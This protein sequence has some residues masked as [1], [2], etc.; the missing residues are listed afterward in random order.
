MSL[1]RIYSLCFLLA[2]SMVFSTAL[3][4]QDTLENYILEYPNQ[5][6]TLMMNKWLEKNEKGTFRF[7][8]LVDPTDDT[9]IT[10]QA[11]VDYGYNWFSVSDAPAIV[12]TPTYD[13]FFSVSVFD[14]K[15]NVPLVVV[16]P[17][18]P[19]VVMRPDQ[20]VPEGDFHVVKLETDQGLIFTRMLVVDN[21][22]EV[23]NLSKSITM[24]GGK[25]DMRRDVQRFSP[26]VEKHALHTIQAVLNSPIGP[27]PDLSFGKVSGDVGML[28]LAAGVFQGQLGTPSDTV[29]YG[30][31][32]ADS[33]GQPL[34]GKDTYLVTVP[35]NIIQHGGYY[36]VTAYGADDKLLIP[37]DKKVYDRTTYSSE[38]NEDGTYTLTLSP[39]GAG[40]NGIPTG[41]PF[42]LILRAYVPVAGANMNLLIEKQ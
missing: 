38:P 35:A 25:G 4:G 12:R 13:K 40:K 1:Q 20:Q 3:Y 23:R 33:E 18:K 21:M 7:T 24:E 34:K 41:K 17:E 14:M 15:H 2:L 42:Y 16:N 31:A 39:S 26:A 22:D 8:G 10:P 28:S 11:T 27:N 29:R 37:N 9:V 5:Q 19:I 36:S 30:I 32:F 6:Q